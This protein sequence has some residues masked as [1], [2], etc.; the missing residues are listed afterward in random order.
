[1][2][3]SRREC[4][5]PQ[6]PEADDGDVND[7]I[8]WTHSAIYLDDVAIFC[9]HSIYSHCLFHIALDAHSPQ[10]KKKKRKINA[11]IESIILLHM[12]AGVYACCMSE[13][14]RRAD[15]GT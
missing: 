5:F 3:R 8:Y 12:V 14:V 7:D 11:Q 13:S 4:F 10:K 9:A 2:G 1:M 6:S 15:V